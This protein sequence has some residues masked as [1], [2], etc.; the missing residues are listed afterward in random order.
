MVLAAH[1]NDNDEVICRFYY[2]YLFCLFF[3]NNYIKTECHA[4]RLDFYPNGTSQNP[5]ADQRY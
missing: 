3:P 5:I 4:A 1:G 2:R